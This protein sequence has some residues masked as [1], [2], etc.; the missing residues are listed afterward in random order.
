MIIIVTTKEIHTQKNISTQRKIFLYTILPPSQKKFLNKRFFPR[1]HEINEF[2]P[3]EK[4]LI[5]TRKKMHFH[6]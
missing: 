5:L 2:L 1:L 3:K 6:A 4:F